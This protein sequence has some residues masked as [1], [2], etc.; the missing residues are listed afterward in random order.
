MS[1]NQA[2]EG[3]KLT[4]LIFQGFVET[5]TGRRR[6]LPD[7]NLPGHNS[8][9]RYGGNEYKR[10]AAERQAVNTTIQGSAA[11]I[12]KK[13]M[14]NIDRSLSNNFPSNYG[15][16]SRSKKSIDCGAFLVLQLHD[17]LIYEVLFR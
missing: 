7:I 16:I 12:V 11:D 5:I 3:I 1:R 15:P 14:I 9:G 17:E 4:I 6:Y 2:N 13:A 8:C 10:A